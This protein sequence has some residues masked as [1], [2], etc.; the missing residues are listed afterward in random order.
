MRTER[1]IIERLEGDFARWCEDKKC[2]GGHAHDQWVN[3]KVAAL[4]WALRCDDP[5]QGATEIWLRREVSRI[6]G[7]VGC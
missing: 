1:G 3:G 4:L 2:W 5:E 7:R 6:T